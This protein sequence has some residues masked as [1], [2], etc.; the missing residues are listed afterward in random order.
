[1]KNDKNT[2]AFGLER[3]E[4]SGIKPYYKP[5]G[6]CER[7]AIA[8]AYADIM[9][10]YG[11]KTASRNSVLR[12]VRRRMDAP[13]DSLVLRLDVT[14]CYETIDYAAVRWT[15]VDDGRVADATLG[16]L[17]SAED[18]YLRSG[19]TRGVPRG[20]STSGLLVELY[21]RVV[22]RRIE[23]MPGVQL[24]RRYV[25][26]SI[27]FFDPRS[28]GADARTL[29]ER[30][31][32]VYGRLGLQL[33]DPDEYPYKG[34]I[35]ESKNDCEF[36]FLGYEII[37]TP[38]REKSV[39]RMPDRA[40]LEYMFVVK[41]AFDTFFCRIGGEADGEA[42][43]AVGGGDYG[44]RRRLSPLAELLGELRHSTSN[45]VV[46]D[47]GRRVKRGLVFSYPFL[48]SDEQLQ[49]MDS[50][51]QSQISRVT[52]DSIPHGFMGAGTHHSA[53]DTA[54]YIRRRCAKF[55]YVAGFRDY[56]FTR[57]E[58]AAADGCGHGR[59]NKARRQARV[60]PNQVAETN[61]VLKKK[62]E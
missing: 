57:R 61:K 55:G 13:D 38:E 20:L 50:F 18:A 53:A 62:R 44:R 59:K 21:L 56:K 27:I 45:R 22:D 33:H 48:T 16:T 31:R 37:R 43:G 24:Y 26:D 34:D 41:K 6:Q 30:V 5:A 8:A 36:P 49:A 29:F 15:L 17:D 19:Q 39:W 10:A 60:N 47:G 23:S 28:A 3:I 42:D 52:P 54:D 51:L 25:D 2:C 46:N 1:M 40:C 32:D 35:I 11:V 58:T 12:G 7:E 14:S 9:S 4:R